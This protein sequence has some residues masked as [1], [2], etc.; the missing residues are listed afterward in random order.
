MLELDVPIAGLKEFPDSFFP[1]T[2]LVQR[3]FTI[4]Q[5]S[6]AEWIKQDYRCESF[7]VPPLEEKDE[8]HA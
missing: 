3:R 6:L 2:T 1:E 8:E 7:I 4:P 5:P